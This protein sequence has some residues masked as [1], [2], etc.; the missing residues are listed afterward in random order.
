MIFTSQMS[1]LSLNQQ[2][3][4]TEW[5]IPTMVFEGSTSRQVGRCL[6]R[7]TDTS[8]PPVGH[9]CVSLYVAGYCT[10][11]LTGTIYAL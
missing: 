2:C 11:V 10:N 8:S 6:S 3:Q 4:S 9:Q 7:V 1:F 5:Q